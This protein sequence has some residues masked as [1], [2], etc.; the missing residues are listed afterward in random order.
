MKKEAL[1]KI[2]TTQS[3]MVNITHVSACCIPI[4]LY[5]ARLFDSSTNFII[6]ATLVAATAMVTAYIWA[7]IIEKTGILEMEVQPSKSQGIYTAIK[8]CFSQLWLIPSQNPVATSD[9]AWSIAVK[10]HGNS[11]R[12][13]ISAATNSTSFSIG[14]ISLGCYYIGFSGE[15][16]ITLDRFVRAL[17]ASVAT[18]L[19]FISIPGVFCMI[20]LF[21]GFFQYFISRSDKNK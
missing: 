19:F 12:G 4:F 11:V 2:E 10:V 13:A 17:N 3:L 15:Y 21:F 16:G 5:F 1:V 8:L 18:Q 7:C 14:L 9:A 20:L 6:S